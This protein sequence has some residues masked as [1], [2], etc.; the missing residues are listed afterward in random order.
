VQNKGSISLLD[1]RADYDIIGR[2]T[3]IEKKL[4]ILQEN[5][6]ILQEKLTIL[7]ENFT[8]LEENLT[9]FTEKFSVFEKNYKND[10]VN[11]KIM[12][13]LSQI[14]IWGMLVL[15]MQK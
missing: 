6:T 13:F 3:D 10:Q 1:R 14:P 2:V 12:F 9:T 5:F 4:T 8:I 11:M 7:Q 15:M